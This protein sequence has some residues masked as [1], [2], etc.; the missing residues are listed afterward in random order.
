MFN[1]CK[2][3]QLLDIREFDFTKVT[4]YSRMFDGVPSSCVIVVKD[5]TAKSW[6]NNKFANRTVRTVEEYGG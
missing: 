1:N 6:I 3:L 5:Y 2:A 4:S